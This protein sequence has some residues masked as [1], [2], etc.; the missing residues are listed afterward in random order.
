MIIK[1]PEQH[2]AAIQ[3]K[4]QHS[5]P[6]SRQDAQNRLFELIM[7]KKLATALP[8]SLPS[9][10]TTL[11]AGVLLNSNPSGTEP[12]SRQDSQ[13]LTQKSTGTSKLR[14][15]ITQ[16]TPR[17]A[18]NAVRQKIDFA[19]AHP[20]TMPVQKAKTQETDTR[21]APL[22]QIS[23]PGDS[24]P[25]SLV[26]ALNK[27]KMSGFDSITLQS[28]HNYTNNAQFIIPASNQTAQTSLDQLLSRA[29][30]FREH[31]PTMSHS[32]RKAYLEHAAYQNIDRSMAASRAQPGDDF[33]PGVLAARF[34]SAN[35]ADAIGYDRRGGT[36]YGIYQL[37]SRMGTM[38]E[39]IEYI[40]DKAPDIAQRLQQAGPANTGGRSGD[41]PK[42]W[43]RLNQEYGSKFADLQHEFIHDKFYVPAARGVQSRTG[44]QMDNAS[45]ALREVLWSTAVQHG[46]HGAMNI[47]Q[48]AAEAVE[49]TKT[50]NPDREMIQAVYHERG[51]RFTGSSEAVRTAVHNRFDQE[52][53]MALAMLPG[54]TD[55]QA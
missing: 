3:D 35:S 22:P 18:S 38:G 34:E 36:C 5:G 43:K 2:M 14:L 51:R 17:Y 11:P 9:G 27:E 47:F 12:G 20:E 33:Q 10:S 37:S 30:P 29:A 40:Q 26:S 50:D 28:A 16:D 49:Y 1:N 44:L 24:I 48:R 52:M 45:P 39:F 8:S 19:G 4:I 46:V 42:E 54:S 15:P 23:D 25:A 55:T 21:P 7:D 13:G 31:D 32:T 41:M 53:R 6:V